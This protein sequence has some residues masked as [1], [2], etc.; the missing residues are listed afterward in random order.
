MFISNLGDL[1]GLVGASASSALALIFP[2]IIHLLT[3][4][5][6]REEDANEERQKKAP[7]CIP[8]L[9]L[10]DIAVII[11][12]M[13]VFAFGSIASL[14]SSVQDFTLIHDVYIACPGTCKFNFSNHQN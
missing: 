10:I 6:E 5:K 9:F 4:W 3:F 8:L 1:I 2:S 12:G 11:F 13:I 14:Y 7:T